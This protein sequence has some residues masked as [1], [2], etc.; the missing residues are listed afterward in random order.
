MKHLTLI[1]I[2]SILSAGSFALPIYQYPEF[3][4]YSKGKVVEVKKL[5]DFSPMSCRQLEY[6]WKRYDVQLETWA[7]ILETT[8]SSRGREALSGALDL[9]H[10]QQKFTLI[11]ELQ[12]HIYELQIHWTPKSLLVDVVDDPASILAIKSDI[13]YEQ[14][15][16]DFFPILERKNYGNV[17]FDFSSNSILLTL[18]VNI[19]DICAKDSIGMFIKADCGNNSNTCEDSEF[20][21]VDL[22]NIKESIVMNREVVNDIK[23]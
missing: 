15:R 5:V 13:F 11:P 16:V 4:E 20:L 10:T 17:N 23:K 6:Q 21:T 18:K 9:V 19:Y 14:S 22:N 7:H 8:L 1:L 12:E 2:I 3:K